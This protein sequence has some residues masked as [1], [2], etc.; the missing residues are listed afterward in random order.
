MNFENEQLLPCG[1]VST[2]A[3]V[4]QYDGCGTQMCVDCEVRCEAC[5]RL[6]CPQH[7]VELSGDHL[8]CPDHVTGHVAKKFLKTLA[9]KL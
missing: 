7:R 9:G 1:H 2:P 6:L 4:C 5:F 8:F 3:G